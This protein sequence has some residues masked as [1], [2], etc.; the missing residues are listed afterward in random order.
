ISG[1]ITSGLRALADAAKRLQEKDYS[2]RVDV[3]PGDEVAAVGLAFNRM[4]EE[5]SYHTENLENLVADRTRALESANEEI[6]GL[7]ARLKSENLRLGA[8]LD[9]ARHIQM[10]V[11]PRRDEL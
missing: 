5:I 10:M 11:L 2:V 1:R 4:A 8:E 3:P 7:N 9:V 6:N